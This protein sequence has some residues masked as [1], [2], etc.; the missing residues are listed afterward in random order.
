MIQWLSPPRNLPGPERRTLFGAFGRSSPG[1][2]HK[3]VNIKLIKLLFLLREARTGSS[4]HGYVRRLPAESLVLDIAAHVTM[5]I[6]QLDPTLRES[7]PHGKVLHG[8]VDR[9]RGSKTVL[10]VPSPF[11]KDR[12]TN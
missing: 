7:N 11:T 2:F 1:S 3:S 8:E 9:F 6:A 5:K 10:K 12:K 4:L